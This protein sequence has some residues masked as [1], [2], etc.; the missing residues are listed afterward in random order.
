MNHTPIRKIKFHS[1]S[2]KNV[3]IQNALLSNGIIYFEDLVNYAEKDV[4]KFSY[5]G[6][7][8]INA[9]K[10]TMKKNKLNF[11]STCSLCGKER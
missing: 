9:I 11:K 4:L 7:M 2:K 5:I 10:E 8:C 1:I 3:L 6:V